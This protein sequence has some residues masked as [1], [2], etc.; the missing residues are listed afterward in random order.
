MREE[1]REIAGLLT[2]VVRPEG[3]AE[4]SVVM[5]HGYAMQP[6]DLAPFAHSMKV[7]A[8]FYFPRGPLP[9]HAQGFAW[10][11]IDVETK[12]TALTNGPRDLADAYPAGREAARNRMQL[13][14][15]AIKSDTANC[16]LILGGFSQGG[17]L[18]C[19]LTLHGICKPA[20]MMLL[21]A[22]RIALNEWHP[23]LGTLRDL[24]SLVSHGRADPDLAYSAGENL[25]DMLLAANA[26]VTWIGFDQGHEIPL[27]VWRAMRRFLAKVIEGHRSQSGE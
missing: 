11:P 18:A 15:T 10:W 13:F 7:P 4:A 3:A 6:T 24:P 12:N 2:A 20:G 14:L 22:S 16:P 23:R 26:R 17:M 8:T 9:A 21:S 5:L 25:R 27:T 1:I 19:E